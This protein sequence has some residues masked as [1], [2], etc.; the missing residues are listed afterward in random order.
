MYI[1]CRSGLIQG[2]NIE[3]PVLRLIIGRTLHF[4]LT[5]SESIAYTLQLY[6]HQYI[7]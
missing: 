4:P 5:P 2:V 1:M 3:V 6:C 7:Q